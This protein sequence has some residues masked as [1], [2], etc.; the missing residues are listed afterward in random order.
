MLGI[1]EIRKVISHMRKIGADTQTCEVKE[2]VQ[3][4]P[5]SLTETISAFSNKAGGL[6]GLPKII[7]DRNF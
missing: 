2:A 6:R 5:K 3:A 7:R 1:V 4:I